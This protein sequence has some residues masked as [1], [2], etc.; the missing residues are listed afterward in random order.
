LPA[1]KAVASDRRL[2]KASIAAKK[3]TPADVWNNMV[4]AAEAGVLRGSLAEFLAYGPGAAK[5]PAL[6][7][8]FR[9]GQNEESRTIEQA[10]ESAGLES[11]LIE[12]RW[13]A[14]ALGS[15]K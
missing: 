4:E 10:L 11:K 2:V 5:F 9:P 6:V 3:R 12:A 8:G 13:G 7:V 1:D 15:G 14:W